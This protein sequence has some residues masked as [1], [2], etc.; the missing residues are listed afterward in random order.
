MK[1]GVK[2]LLTKKRVLEEFSQG[3][4]VHGAIYWFRGDSVDSKTFHNSF[5]MTEKDQLVLPDIKRSVVI[6]SDESVEQTDRGF[7]VICQEDGVS[8]EVHINHNID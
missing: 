5:V 2:Y 6:V 7:K 8:V 4:K 3:L 1:K